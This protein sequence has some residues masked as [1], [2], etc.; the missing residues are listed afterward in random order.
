MFTG[1]DTGPILRRFKVVNSNE[2]PP[3]ALE[4]EHGGDP[5]VVQ[6]REEVGGE[7]GGNVSQDLLQVITRWLMLLA[8]EL[9]DCKVWRLRN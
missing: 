8:Q 1:E 2:L 4:D 7:E 5:E 3:P 9:L 6:V